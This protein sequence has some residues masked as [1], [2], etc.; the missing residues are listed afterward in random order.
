M[1][2]CCSMIYDIRPEFLE[3]RID[4]VRITHRSNQYLQIQCRMLAQQ[5]LLD[6]ISIVLIYIYN[7]QAFGMVGSDLSA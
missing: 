7:D 3:Y 2:V 4:P 1:L 5:F 6:I